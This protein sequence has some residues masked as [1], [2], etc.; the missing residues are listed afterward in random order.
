MTALIITNASQGVFAVH[1]FESEWSSFY[2]VGTVCVT[3]VRVD[4]TVTSCLYVTNELSETEVIQCA[5]HCTE[6]CRKCFVWPG[7]RSETYIHR[8]ANEHTKQKCQCL[9]CH[10]HPPQLL[11]TH[12]RSR[13]TQ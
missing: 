10:D 8:A 5:I 9:K 13:R 11:K 1:V 7:L 2:S 6:N 12:Y 3:I 4:Q